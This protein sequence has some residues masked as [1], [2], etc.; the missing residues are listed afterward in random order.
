MDHHCRTYLPI[1]L[2]IHFNR[3][4]RLIHLNPFLAWL[5]NCIGHFNHRYFFM[6][7]IFAWLGTLLVIVFGIPVA[8]NHY[9]NVDVFSE[10]FQLSKLFALN[11]YLNAST[12]LDP[13]I[14]EMD[15]YMQTTFFDTL[16]ADYQN[17]KNNFIIFELLLTVSAFVA[18][19][20]LM[21]WHARMIT[22]GETCIESLRNKK[23][24][25]R[26]RG[27]R[28][29]FFNPFD[30]GR[31]NNW[32]RFFGLNQKGIRLRHVFFPSTHKPW[33]DGIEWDM[34]YD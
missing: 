26:L 7:C 27:A 19:G 18:I 8:L 29:R 30:K 11:T 15:D 28:E 2:P 14:V 13:S 5:N 6:F 23:E 9:L 10:H 16:K 20:V 31:K 32:R 21:G 25:L 1:T 12:N 17:V 3:S 33:N 22:N 34:L 24:R 4:T